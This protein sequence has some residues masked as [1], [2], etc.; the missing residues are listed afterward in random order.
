M[1]KN[2]LEKAVD[3]AMRSNDEIGKLFSQIG[4]SDHPRGVVPIAYRNAR[5]ALQTALKETYPLQS[6]NEVLTSLRTTVHVGMLD[7]LDQAQEK[8]QEFA[9]RQL[10]AYKIPAEP[11]D[12]HGANQQVQNAVAGVIAIVDRQITAIQTALVADLDTTLILGD[13]D[14]VGMFRVGDV[15]AAGA[16]WSATLVWSAFR[17]TV[18]RSG[19]QNGSGKNRIKKLAVA[20]ID[21]RTTN[22]CLKV[23]GQVQPFDK[24]FKLT[25]TPRYAEKLDWA[26]FHD[27][28]RTSI[29][30]YYDEYDMGV[31]DRMKQKAAQTLSNRTNP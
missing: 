20:A 29:A 28:C 22:C 10:Y 26:P 9:G 27:W 15:I 5:R 4:N 2:A 23:H 21:G 30:L 24:P 17:N 8:G 18:S 6:A 14:R 1:P 12:Q 25:G 16:F 3:E 7:V 13:E 19:S 31:T 11:P